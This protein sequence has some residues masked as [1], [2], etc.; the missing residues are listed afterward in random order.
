MVG[1]IFISKRY[2]CCP[3]NSGRRPSHGRVG[4]YNLRNLG[5]CN[6]QFVEHYNVQYDNAVDD[7][8]RRLSPTCGHSRRRNWK[9]PASWQNCVFK[10]PC[11]CQLFQLLHKHFRTIINR[12][13]DT[14][15]VSYRQ[16]H[17][18]INYSG[19]LQCFIVVL[20]KFLTGK[21]SHRL[22]ARL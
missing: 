6:I 4:S 9:G 16:V 5:R 15:A 8:R 3:E 17:N 13:P 12:R 22:R 18:T 14:P 7:S 11:R 20:V 19:I 2:P 10:N 1:G 21:Q